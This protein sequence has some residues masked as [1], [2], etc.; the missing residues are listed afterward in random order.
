MTENL[1]SILIEGATLADITADNVASE[2]LKYL[3]M[4]NSANLTIN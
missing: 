3:K 4:L 2:V 1:T